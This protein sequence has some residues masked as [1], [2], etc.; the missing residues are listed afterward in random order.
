MPEVVGAWQATRSE[1][2][3]EPGECRGLSRW[4]RG[5]RTI[6]PQYSAQIQRWRSMI[7]VKLRFCIEVLRDRFSHF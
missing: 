4:G 5:G 7:I 2:A 3:R 6:R 1:N